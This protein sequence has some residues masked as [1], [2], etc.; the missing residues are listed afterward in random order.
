MSPTDAAP[1]NVP[2]VSLGTY[3]GP[4]LSQSATEDFKTS[5]AEEGTPEDIRR[6]FFPGAPAFDPSLEWVQPAEP[7][8]STSSTSPASAVRF[9]LDGKP[10]PAELSSS[11]PTHLGLHHH[12]EGEH[13][14][15]NA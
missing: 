14:R 7:T 12:A 9:D 13:A 1:S 4:L 10:I 11:L 15:Y 8:G 5:A 2:V 3:K 6:R